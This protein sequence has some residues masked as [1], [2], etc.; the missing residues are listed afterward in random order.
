MVRYSSYYNRWN[1]R[2]TTLD[3]NYSYNTMKEFLRLMITSHSGI[4]SK[5]VCGV[6]GFFII[7]FVLIYC[8]MYSIQAPL[9]VEPFIYAVCLLLGIDS[10]T[11][12]WKGKM[13]DQ[14]LDRR[15][16]DIG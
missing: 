13:D 2:T 16:R 7:I 9:M 4:S 3:N 8:T 6:I 12:I 15:Y 14:I 5:R 11:G 10:V 1:Y